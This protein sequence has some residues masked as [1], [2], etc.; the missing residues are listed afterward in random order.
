MSFLTSFA[1]CDWTGP[2]GLLQRP[3]APESPFKDVLGWIIVFFVIV[4]PILRGIMETARTQR[5]EFE[6]KE[7]KQAKGAAGPPRPARRKRTLEEI[8]EG[9][10]E[11]ADVD[12]RAP[13][14]A[15]TAAPA[16]P[17]VSRATVP[18]SA[19]PAARFGERPAGESTAPVYRA[20]DLLGGDS[21]AD[22]YGEDS[23]DLVG[24]PYD[25]AAMTRDLVPDAKL[26]RIPTE[27]EVEAGSPMSG[28]QARGVTAATVANQP[29]RLAA[30]PVP[31]NLV[32]EDPEVLFGRL[33]KPL[34][35]WQKAFVLREVLGT[36]LSSRPSPTLTDLPD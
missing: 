3:Q 12:V 16:R 30:A 15:S 29:G 36:P 23:V 32:R 21:Y 27:D 17:P 11:R 8:L 34:T 2:L 5:K 26:R 19:P 14:E 10:L 35:P 31:A 22:S 28:T 24:D 13:S 7:G 20:N 9:K 1:G 18:K 6:E 4:W 25:E 33:K